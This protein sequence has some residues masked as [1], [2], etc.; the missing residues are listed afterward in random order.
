[1]ALEQT[2]IQTV[3]KLLVSKV[4][5]KSWSTADKVT[6]DIQIK[7]KWFE[8]RKTRT[9]VTMQTLG[10]NPSRAAQHL[11]SKPVS[12]VW[13]WELELMSKYHYKTKWILWN[14]I[15][16]LLTASSSLQVLTSP[17][18]GWSAPSIMGWLI[19]INGRSC[20]FQFSGPTY[21][22]LVFSG[23]THSGQN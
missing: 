12:T 14:Q 11:I 20:R 13:D 9:A 18:K 7:R 3:L 10:H 16:S 23:F 4:A 5:E 8:P 15:L 17:R 6:P 19:A 1:M 22:K 21:S 2:G